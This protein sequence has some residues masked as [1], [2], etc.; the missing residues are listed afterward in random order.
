MNRVL[1]KIYYITLTMRLLHILII[2]SLSIITISMISD[3]INICENHTI[4]R[5]SIDVITHQ[6]L[7]ILSLLIYSYAA[8]VSIKSQTFQIAFSKIEMFFSILFTIFVDLDHFI[9]AKSLSLYK[10]THLV[11]RPWGHCL[12]FVLMVYIIILY[13]IPKDSHIHIIYLLATVTHLI[14]DA[15]RRGLWL[16][17]TSILHISYTT[18]LILL[19]I[20]P[21][22]LYYIHKHS[23]SVLT[24]LHVRRRSLYGRDV[25][26]ISQ[27]PSHDQSIRYTTSMREVV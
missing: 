24:V 9:A 4:C 15:S 25:V 27:P 12:L 21:I 5:I 1:F 7:S 6:I 13:L 22:S 2:S 16:Y 14:R 23:V 19:C 20:Y 18:H 11:S 10:A 17:Y 8:C 3:T 26:S